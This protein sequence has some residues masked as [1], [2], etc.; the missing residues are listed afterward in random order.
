MGVFFTS[1]IMLCLTAYS[2][3]VSFQPEW[4]PALPIDAFTLNEGRAY[5]SI[6]VTIP[7]A[8]PDDDGEAPSEDEAQ[9]ESVASSQNETQSENKMRPEDDAPAETREQTLT[10]RRHSAGMLEAFPVWDGAGFLQI[11][12]RYD[13]GVLTRLSG[14]RDDFSFDA[15][16]L[17]T[18]EYAAHN[19]TLR[20][21]RIVRVNL[22]G[23]YHFASL[24]YYGREI[25]ETWF[26]AGGVPETLMTLTMRAENPLQCTH[27]VVQ[28][29]DANQNIFYSY[30]SFG[31][32]T[33]IETPEE[34]VT[35]LY[36]HKGLVYLTRN[37]TEHCAFQKDERGR[38]VRTQVIGANEESGEDDVRYHSYTYKFNNRGDWTEREELIL[39]EQFG[40]LLPEGS[41]IV[42]RVINY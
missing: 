42:T 34:T 27:L 7:L 23:E 10:A 5:R 12:V 32:K 22:N 28:S 4:S 19:T 24:A 30:D 21:P 25:I 26:S 2:G 40:V 20:V 38:L 36:N 9:T 33:G 41:E 29:A 35:T 11:E 6:S 31:N 15:E 8:Q 17:E 1:L 3:E 14:A 16:V 39:T 18:G 13:N 37:E